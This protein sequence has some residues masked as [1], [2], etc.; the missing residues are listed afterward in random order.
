M[1]GGGLTGVCVGLTD[2]HYHYHQW[3]V[4]DEWVMV[5]DLWCIGLWYVGFWCV[6]LLLQALYQHRFA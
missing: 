1:A 4:W 6:V 5:V 3:C 2:H